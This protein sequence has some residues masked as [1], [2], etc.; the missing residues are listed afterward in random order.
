MTLPVTPADVTAAAERIRPFVHRTPIFTSATLD[1]EPGARDVRQSVKGVTQGGG[2]LGEFER[3]RRGA[4]LSGVSV[5]A[6]RNHRG[7]GGGTRS[8]QLGWG[9]DRGRALLAAATCQ[10]HEEGNKHDR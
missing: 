10:P 6:D 5:L 2:F 1:R 8:C 3:D 4:S 9:S 7:A